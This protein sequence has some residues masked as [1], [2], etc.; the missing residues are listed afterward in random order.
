MLF[1]PHGH[2]LCIQMPMRARHDF[3]LESLATP[4]VAVPSLSFLKRCSLKAMHTRSWLGPSRRK[5]RSKQLCLH[6]QPAIVL[7]RHTSTAVLQ[8]PTAKCSPMAIPKAVA[9]TTMRTKRGRLARLN[10]DYLAK[11]RTSYSAVLPSHP[12][13]RKSKQQDG[14][15][16]CQ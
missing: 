8:A 6:H 14:Q 11:P 4:R 13:M 3:A 9:E 16:Q 10:K 5:S 2:H 15:C 12:S 7:A 1:S